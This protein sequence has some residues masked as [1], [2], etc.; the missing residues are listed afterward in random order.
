MGR[1]GECQP[2]APVD[3]QGVLQWDARGSRDAPGSR[4]FISVQQV[5]KTVR[6]S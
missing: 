5:L 3:A 6:I 2:T 4:I 1:C